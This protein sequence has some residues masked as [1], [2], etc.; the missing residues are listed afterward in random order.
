MDVALLL[1]IHT[2]AASPSSSETPLVVQLHTVWHGQ[3]LSMHVGIIC[4]GMYVQRT[5]GFHLSAFHVS[6]VGGLLW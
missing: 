1:T 2:D 5:E 6:S 4:S 3:F